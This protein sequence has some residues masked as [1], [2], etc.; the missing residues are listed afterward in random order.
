MTNRSSITLGIFDGVHIGHRRLLSKAVELK[1]EGGKSMALTFEYSAP[2]YLN[3][4]AYIEKSGLGMI[5]SAARRE[6]IIKSLGIDE[7]VF[8]DFEKMRNLTPVEFIHY[9]M[10]H[11]NPA[12]VIVGFNFHFGRDRLGDSELLAEL[13]HRYGFRTTIVPPVNFSGHRVSSSLIRYF[14]KNGDIGHANEVLKRHYSIEGHVYRDQQIGRTIGFPTANIR[15]T[16]SNLLIPAYGV[17]LAYTPELGYG[18]L[19]VGSR[20]TV[21]YEDMVH[22]EIYYIDRNFDLYDKDIICYIIEYLRCEKK[23]DSLDEL[24]DEIRNDEAISKQLIQLWESRSG[25]WENDF[26]K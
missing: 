18:L 17:Y 6:K 8:M 20:P 2:Y 10:E 12:E 1:P 16:K 25:W 4:K 23:F 15:R 21:S 19:N 5:Y 3:P 22:Y 13:G 11:Y 7:V 14:I 26:E 24:K 9:L